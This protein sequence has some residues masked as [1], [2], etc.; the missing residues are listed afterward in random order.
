MDD[1]HRHPV[2][3]ALCLRTWC[4]LQ[5]GCVDIHTPPCKIH[6]VH[7]REVPYREGCVCLLPPLQYGLFTP[8]S[9]WQSRGKRR[10]LQGWKLQTA[11]LCAKAKE[12]G[13]VELKCPGWVPLQYGLFT[14]ELQWQSRGKLTYLTGAGPPNPCKIRHTYTQWIAR[15]DLVHV[16]RLI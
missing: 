3:T 9:Q 1:T 14:P 5:K 7:M 13:A 4:L 16:S 15:V 11:T 2:R 12:N 8:E 6:S 10:S